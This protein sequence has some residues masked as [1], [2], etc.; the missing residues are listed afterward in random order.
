MQ[1]PLQDAQAR[2]IFRAQ[3]V[4]RGDIENFVP[5]PEDLDYPERNRVIQVPLTSNRPTKALDP[6]SPMEGENPSQFDTDAVFQGW[7]PSLRKSVWLLSR[8]YRLVNVSYPRM[9]NLCIFTDI[10]LVYSIRR[11]STSS[12]PCLHCLSN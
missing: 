1:S 6:V 11:S 10:W 2:I 12:G 5:K 7:Y 9:K 4:I 8:I 3:N